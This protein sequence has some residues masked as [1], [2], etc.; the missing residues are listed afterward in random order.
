MPYIFYAENKKHE[1]SIL[2]KTS[3][4]KIPPTHVSHELYSFVPWW[5]LAKTA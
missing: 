1:I 5:Y 2:S 3:S 4:E